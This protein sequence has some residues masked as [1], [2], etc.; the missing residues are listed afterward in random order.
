MVCPVEDCPHPT[1]FKTQNGLNKH[2]RVHHADHAD[3]L[4][5]I[6]YKNTSFYKNHKNAFDEQLL[7]TLQKDDGSVWGDRNQETD[8][9]MV[10]LD[11]KA[12]DS[13]DKRES[14]V[15]SV[16]ECGGRR[17]YIE[18]ICEKYVTNYCE[19]ETKEEI[20]KE[21]GFED[22]VNLL[23]GAELHQIANELAEG[24]VV[25]PWQQNSKSLL[26][27]FV[28]EPIKY[29]EDYKGETLPTEEEFL[30]IQQRLQQNKQNSE[31][32]RKRDELDQF[33]DVDE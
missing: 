9:S 3:D 4:I 27:E 14:Y 22:K 1:V 13:V 8:C 19:V 21:L 23:E 29:K 24:D 28:P 25:Q 10:V 12:K 15:R 2:I 30:A 32:K 6:E 26:E 31:L 17:G 20:L 5:N 7:L 18:A 33:A 11:Q 16:M